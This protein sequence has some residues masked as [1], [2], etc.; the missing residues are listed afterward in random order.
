MTNIRNIQ[1]IY[2]NENC[3]EVC[4]EAHVRTLIDNM[5][6][7]KRTVKTPDMNVKIITTI[8]I[9]NHEFPNLKSYVHEM[10]RM[11][12]KFKQRMVKSVSL[13]R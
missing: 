4:R 12:L 11:Y 1:V 3:M 10:E 6:I 7:F 13:S 5:I 2:E 8:T 9:N